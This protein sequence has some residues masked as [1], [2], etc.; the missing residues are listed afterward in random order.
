LQIS[1]GEPGSMATAAAQLVS[2]EH[3]GR[4]W[5]AEGGGAGMTVEP[6]QQLHESAHGLIDAGQ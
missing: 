5:C 3:G 4:L 1:P 6:G 2:F